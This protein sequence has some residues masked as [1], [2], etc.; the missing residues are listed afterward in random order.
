MRLYT[1]DTKTVFIEHKGKLLNWGLLVTPNGWKGTPESLFVEINAYWDTLPAASQDGLYK[2]YTRAREA[3]AQNSSDSARMCT[4]LQDRMAAVIDTYHPFEAVAAVVREAKIVYPDNVDVDYDSNSDRKCREMTYTKSEYFDLVVLATI[5]RSV[6]PIWNM[7][8]AYASSLDRTK[9]GN[10]S[11]VYVDIDTLRTLKYTEFIS[12]P[13]MNRLETYVRVSAENLRQK[14]DAGTQMSSAVAGP[15]SAEVPHYLLASAIANKL[16]TAPVN[17]SRGNINL[18]TSIYLKVS[19]DCDHLNTKFEVKVGERTDRRMGGEDD[20]KIGYLE[21]YGAR[22]RVSDLV[23]VVNEVFMED[24]RQLRMHIDPDIPASVVKRL[25]DSHH[26]TQLHISDVQQELM[27]WIYSLAGQPRAT[28]DV[29][30][31]AT[32]SAI[33]VSQAALLLWGF[34]ELAAWL[35]CNA[36]ECDEMGDTP[37]HQL[38]A[39]L[40]ERLAAIYSYSRNSYQRQARGSKC[41]QISA[42]AN[43]IDELCNLIANYKWEMS[44]TEDALSLLKTTAGAYKIPENLKSQLAELLLIIDRKRE[45]YYPC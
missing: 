26:K 19:Q 14:S 8:R 34:P 16:I 35:S 37:M 12:C 6:L 18:I 43:A 5:L 30:R 15:G 24:Y 1:D 22:Q 44:A 40:R 39:D 13:V 28:D 7:F 9:S 3:I 4:A 27:K 23:Y 33:A 21:G 31:L 10:V 38:P 20:D 45:I 29:S 36:V 2:A 32:L 25:L 42:G 17:D 11:P 41:Q